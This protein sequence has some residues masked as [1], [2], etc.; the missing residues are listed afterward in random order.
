MFFITCFTA[1]LL[2]F[3]TASHTHLLHSSYPFPIS[4]LPHSITA[5]SLLLLTTKLL[6]HIL[7]KTL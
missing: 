1:L 5:Y 3:F 7:S 2:Y 6:L 4:S